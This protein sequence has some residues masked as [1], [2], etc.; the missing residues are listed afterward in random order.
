MHRS[1]GVK[2]TIPWVDLEIFA[3]CSGPIYRQSEYNYGA[4]IS[5]QHSP[6]VAF[7][8]QKLWEKRRAS[9]MGSKKRQVY[10][11][12]ADFLKTW[13]TKT[14]SFS[15]EPL[16]IKGFTTPQNHTKENGEGKE[17]SV[18]KKDWKYASHSHIWLFVSLLFF[19]FHF[20]Y[21]YIYLL[22][23]FVQFILL[24]SPVMGW[25]IIK[26]MYNEPTTYLTGH[27]WQHGVE[28]FS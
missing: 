5:D 4:W 11:S 24:K 2:W 15:P 21:F 14:S 28:L 25:G 27:G 19:T 17:E 3:V 13:S 26:C 10:R 6:G 7:R 8:Q 9:V 22:L 1:C 23:I 16:S 20:I 12:L 18:G